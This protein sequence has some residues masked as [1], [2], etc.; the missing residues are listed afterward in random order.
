VRP[1]PKWR[2]NDNIKMTLKGKGYGLDST[3]SRVQRR[4]FLNTVI[5]HG[6]P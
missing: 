5:D 3:D 2:E 6:V 1:K 4:N